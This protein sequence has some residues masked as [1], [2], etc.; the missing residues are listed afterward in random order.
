MRCVDASF[1]LDLANGHPRA[2][3]KAKEYDSKGESLTIPAPAL[4]EFLIGAF[5]R[6][7]A[8]LS[9]A[10]E[11]VAS[12]AV[13]ETTESIAGEAARLGGE[14]LRNGTPVGTLDLLIA[15]TAQHHRAT[16]VTRD[17]D[18]SRIPGIIIETY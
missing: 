10:L 18:C 7:G 17:R 6:G 1:C 2:V 11:L 15:A 14:C 5:S 8:T 16:L 3:R 12:F 13:L 9:Q 4:T